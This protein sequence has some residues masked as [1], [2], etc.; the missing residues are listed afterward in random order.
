M[1][2][3]K[4]TI[5]A[6]GLPIV[7]HQAG[8]DE[9][10]RILLLSQETPWCTEF[11]ALIRHLGMRLK[12]LDSPVDALVHFH[13]FDPHIFVVNAFN[14]DDLSL[15]DLC[16]A[17]RIPRLLRPLALL[18]TDGVPI[19]PGEDL[20]E[21]G[22]DEVFNTGHSLDDYSTTLI[23]HF[24]LTVAQ[25][26][27]LDRERDILDSLPDALMVVDDDLILWK[28]NRAFA[29]L[30]GL[31][32][33]E[34]LR[35]HLGQP[36]TA[37][38]SGIVSGS[39]E[40][41][42]GASLVTGLATAL[43]NDRKSFDCRE[44]IGQSER[45]LAGQVTRLES[46]PSHALIALRDVTDQQQAVL[47]ESR[48]E[49]LATIGNLSVG[50]AHEIQNPNTFSR[51]N[52]AN[53]KALFS[54]LK[55]LL[56]ERAGEKSDWKVGTL[57]L[58]TVLDKIDEAVSG[59]EMAS[60][61]IAAV[62]DT[63]K[64]FGQTSGDSITDCN[65]AEAVMEAVI[66][67]KHVLREHA[68]LAVDLPQNLP[69]VRAATSEL[70]QVFINLIENACNAFTFPGPQARGDGPAEIRIHMERMD[71]RELVIAVTDNGP[72]IEEELQAQIF[73]PYFTTQEQGEG[74]GLGLSLSSDLMHRFG[75]DLTVRSRRGQ[76]ASF[77]VTLQRADAQ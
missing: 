4:D 1:S 41:G 14:G 5:P 9:L 54:A 61:R 43:R 28:V 56:E 17:L 72:G 73:R 37:V 18:V 12:R 22:V 53:L 68:Q 59:V 57:P 77:L 15:T 76:G 52:A 42:V 47:R 45:F 67:T 31:D 44:L 10:C 74:T 69:F 24:R 70:A 29:R 51:V 16:D 46:N 8:T 3:L 25:R 2:Y 7:P 48:R 38:L 35:R 66:L 20:A 34:P 30:F 49:R 39:A 71:E 60:Q 21:L 11:K 63:L 19:P 75:G 64:R 50:V 6:P 32:N 62:L 26:R 55:P 65:A 58:K 40:S 13:E 36:L 27:V 33:A 23:Q